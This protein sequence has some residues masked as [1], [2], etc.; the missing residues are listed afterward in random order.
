M[1]GSAMTSATARPQDA[2]G[3]AQHP[4]LVSG[5][6]DDAVGDHDVDGRVGQRDVLDVAL[7]ELG[8]AR[9]RIR[10]VRPGEREHLV[11]H[12]RTDRAARRA[13]PLG[14]DEHVGAGAR[15]EVEDG[16]AR[17]EVGD[18]GRDAAA[19]RRL[20]GRGVCAGGL[21]AVERGAEDLGAGGV[22]GAQIG[23][24]AARR[25]AVG[26]PAATTARAFGDAVGGRGVARP[27]DLADVGV[28][29]QLSY[30]RPS[31]S[32]RLK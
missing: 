11:G 16:L 7:D 4:R 8:V 30:R 2:R 19:E 27:D 1:S 23:V 18:A 13:D 6:V 17:V 32:N 24:G 22:G 15:A 21:V 9:A 3:L 25:R 14:A 12:I 20:D 5:E 26:S 29:A 10:R 28:L 31:I